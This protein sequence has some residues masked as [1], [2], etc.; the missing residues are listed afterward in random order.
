MNSKTLEIIYRQF[1]KEHVSRFI[2]DTNCLKRKLPVRRR[3]LLGSRIIPTTRV[4]QRELNWRRRPGN[5][6]PRHG[7][8]G[9]TSSRGTIYIARRRNH[10]VIAAPLSDT[11]TPRPRADYSCKWDCSASQQFTAQRASNTPILPALLLIFSLPLPSPLTAPRQ[12][13]EKPVQD[14]FVLF[15]LL[16][17]QDRLFLNGIYRGTST[18]ISSSRV[19]LARSTERG[20]ASKWDSPT[21]PAR[22]PT[23]F[24]GS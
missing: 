11:A 19:S 16:S 1:R 3:I 18:G 12:S 7:P 22:L 4:E 24:A 23:D 21:L 6:S 13:A 14:Y 20:R 15:L 8:D 17:G 9:A 2:R 10:T 5:V